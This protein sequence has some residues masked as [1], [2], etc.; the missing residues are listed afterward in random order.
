M[1][2]VH[3]ITNAKVDWAP[4]ILSDE[5]ERRLRPKLLASIDAA[6]LAVADGPRAQESNWCLRCSYRSVCPQ[7]DMARFEQV[8]TVPDL[9]VN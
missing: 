6:A 7:A 8:E 9:G 4:P 2:G 1:L 3:W 5:I